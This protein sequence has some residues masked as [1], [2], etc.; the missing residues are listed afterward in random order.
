[1]FEFRFYLGMSSADPAGVLFYPALFRHAHDA[2]E[3][4]MREN[5]MALE[6]ILAEGRHALPIAHAEADYRRPLRHGAAVTV[7]VTIGRLG[8]SSFNVDFDFRDDSGISCATAHSVHVV[9][10]RTTGARTPIP[11]TWRRRL[12]KHLQPQ[13]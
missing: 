1:M 13:S 5:E 10:D 6:A 11:E 2:Y 9:V 4:F 7:A 12:E 3:A 8:E